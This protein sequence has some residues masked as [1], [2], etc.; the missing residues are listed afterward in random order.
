MID[1]S[2]KREA[3][4]MA[5]MRAALLNLSAS[6]AQQI[7]RLEKLGVS[8]SADELALEFDDAFFLARD[9]LSGSLAKAIASLNELLEK[10]SNAT[11][12]NIWSV[13]GLQKAAEWRHVRRLAREALDV[14][15]AAD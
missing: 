2:S 8:P 13:E 14:F 5:K 7:A 15:E 1:P 11:D 12:K 4:A 3:A 10:M 6:S 9:L